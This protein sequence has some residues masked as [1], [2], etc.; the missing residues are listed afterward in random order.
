MKSTNQERLK[1]ANPNGRPLPSRFARTLYAPITR[2]KN[3][4]R[5]TPHQVGAVIHDFYGTSYRVELTG[6]LR[7]SVL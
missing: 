2:D 5:I 3:G 1:Q 4:D 7:R 6:E